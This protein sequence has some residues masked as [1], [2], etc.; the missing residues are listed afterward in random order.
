MRTDSV[1]VENGTWKGYDVWYVTPIAT[2]DV[3]EALPYFVLSDG[4]SFRKANIPS[5][6]LE[7]IRFFGTI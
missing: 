1:T 4:V 2:T 5:E 3:I 6:S 7:L